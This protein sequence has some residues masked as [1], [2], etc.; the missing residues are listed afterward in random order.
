MH[1]L[2]GLVIAVASAVTIWK[3]DELA[4]LF[5]SAPWN[6]RRENGADFYRGWQ[7]QLGGLVGLLVAAGVI[8][9]SP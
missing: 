9:G 4:N 3:A 6:S 7:I 5:N 2:G 1:L 8:L